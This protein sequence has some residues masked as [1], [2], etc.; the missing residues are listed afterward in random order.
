MLRHV[1]L[2]GALAAL[3]LI[4][5]IAMVPGEREQWTM[6]VRD[7]RNQE[8]LA[9]L[10]AR[11]EAGRREPDAVV[12]LYRLYM[13]FAEIDKATGVMQEFANSQP[14][15]AQ[16]IAMLAR[17][18]ADIQ[19]KTN[20]MRALE[21]LFELQPS[22]QTARELLANYRLNGEFA[23]EQELLRSLLA[24]EMITANDAERLGLMLIAQHDVYGAR[25][26]LIRFDEIANPERTI[27]RFVLFD[28]LVQTGDG[29]GALSRAASWIAHFRKAGVHRGGAG[30]AAY[31]RLI[32][33]MLA[34]D[35][36]ETRRLLC[37]LSV[38]GTLE[39]GADISCDAAVSGMY[40]EPEGTG[41]TVTHATS[42]DGFGRRKR[43]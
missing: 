39:R 38:V 24:H 42:R 31:E 5:G 19:D 13:G 16:R 23:R 29:A 32:R 10:E 9:M 37:D 25:E 18:Y 7:G 41:T 20:E 12:H 34:V 26:A 4:A 27:G 3:A 36:V 43:Q 11:Y 1:A 17:H 35:E 40:S 22:V 28:V 21:T 6:L 33:M 2:L 14:D 15:D 30:T 8:A